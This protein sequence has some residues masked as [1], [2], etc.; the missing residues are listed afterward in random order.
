[1]LLDGHVLIIVLERLPVFIDLNGVAIENAHGDTLPA[2]FNS[3][4]SRRNPA[5]EGAILPS[6]VHGDFDVGFLSGLIVT[7][8]DPVDCAGEESAAA[9]AFA[10]SSGRTGLARRT[11]G[12][13]AAGFAGGGDGGGET[14]AATGGAVAAA[15]GAGAA[16]IVGVVGAGVAI[17]VFAVA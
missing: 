17:F 6:I 5:L 14:A 4:I 15:V 8:F 11:S 1:M 16:G 3:A 7:R 13:D 9:A 12:S 10:R 2:K